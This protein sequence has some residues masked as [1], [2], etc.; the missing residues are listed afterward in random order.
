M[1]KSMYRSLTANLCTHP[2]GAFP[3]ARDESHLKHKGLD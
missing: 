1:I 3:C 2:Q